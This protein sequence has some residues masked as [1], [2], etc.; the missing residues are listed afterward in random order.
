[1]DDQS[2]V[3]DGARPLGLGAERLE[4]L[5]VVQFDSWTPPAAYS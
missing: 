4:I 2:R 1:M 5:M 3:V